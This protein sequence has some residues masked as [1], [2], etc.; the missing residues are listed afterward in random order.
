[1]YFKLN[2]EVYYIDGKK[3]GILC[4]LFDNKIY[5]LNNKEKNLIKISEN[6]LSIDKNEFYDKLEKLCIGKYYE[7]LPYIQKLRLI[8]FTDDDEKFNFKK[9]FIELN[10]SCMNDCNYCGNNGIYKRSYG[11]LGCNIFEEQGQELSTEE[12]IQIIDK[13]EKIGCEN[14]YFVGGDLSNNW[15]TTKNI[16]DYS[17]N[18][19]PLMHISIHQ[20]NIS[21]EI[22]EYMLNN[23][24]LTFIIQIEFENIQNYNLIRKDNFIYLIT[25]KPSD[26]SKFN[27][28]KRD[29]EDIQ[30]IPD[31]LSNDSYNVYNPN[32]DNN[33]NFNINSF[34]HNLEFH[35]CLGKSL[36]ISS[37]GDIFICP[38]LRTNPI[39]NIKEK[40][41][42]QI[43]YENKDFLL[44]VWKHNLDKIEGCCECEFRYFCNDCRFIEE[45]LTSKQK[46]KSL[47]SKVK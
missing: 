27:N 32:L 37:N 6:N 36:F 34:F 17:K 16:L 46:S 4:D 24:N 30:F 26:Y 9:I 11:C 39:S 13:I 35:P 15:E 42:Y 33:Y 1:M 21:N 25:I 31:F 7:E 14:I 3:R 28:F 47:C 10:S 20:K 18:K 5:H 22:K 19:F 41:L 38:M 23:N 8:S 45:N 29:I 12:I 40:E 44:D 43:F 2:P